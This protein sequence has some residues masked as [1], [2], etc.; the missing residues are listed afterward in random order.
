MSS[1][2]TMSYCRTNSINFQKFTNYLIIYEEKSFQDD[3]H[4]KLDALER[5][6]TNDKE[7]ILA[8]RAKL[9]EKK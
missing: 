3:N 8:K 6:S 5:K 9:A 4:N 2:R 1:C 7:E